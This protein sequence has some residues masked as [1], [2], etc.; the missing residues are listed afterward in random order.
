[1][2]GSAPPNV[3]SKF[4]VVHEIRRSDGVSIFW[5]A[6][7][8]RTVFFLAWGGVVGEGVA[9]VLFGSVLDGMVLVLC[10]VGVG[11]IGAAIAGAGAGVGAGVDTV[12]VLL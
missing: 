8:V 2:S 3:K 1:M 9:A 10:V 12:L 6:Q 11:I 7:L 5:L 4:A